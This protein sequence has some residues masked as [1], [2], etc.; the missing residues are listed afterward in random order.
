MEQSKAM[1]YRSQTASPKVLKP[2]Y[3]CN[4]FCMISGFRR[5]VD[6]NCTLLGYY[7]ASI[8]S[9]LPKFR[10]NLSVLSF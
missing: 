7:A 6:K 10:D 3:I 5:E 1:E 2:H 8:G 4:L 9:S